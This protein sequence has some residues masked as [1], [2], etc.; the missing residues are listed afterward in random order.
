MY[1]EHCFPDYIVRGKA[2]FDIGGR[3]RVEVV[4]LS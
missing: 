1:L 4:H 2:F 3:E